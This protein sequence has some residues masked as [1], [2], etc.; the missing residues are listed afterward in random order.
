VISVNSLPSVKFTNRIFVVLTECNEEPRDE[1]KAAALECVYR[2]SECATDC[3]CLT[4]SGIM[5]LR[6]LLTF[7]RATTF[8]ERA[9]R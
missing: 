9:V 3:F 1:M 5:G 2:G 6:I 4:L 8:L 7:L